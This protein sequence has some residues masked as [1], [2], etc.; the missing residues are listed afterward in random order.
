[1]AKEWSIWAT[2][3]SVCPSCS[4]N[5]S[6]QRLKE[7]KCNK[8][9]SCQLPPAQVRKRAFV[10]TQFQRKQS[11]LIIKD[12]GCMTSQTPLRVRISGT[13]VARRTK[14]GHNVHHTQAVV[15][16]GSD[17]GLDPWGHPQAPRKGPIKEECVSESLSYKNWCV[18]RA[19]F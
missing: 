2:T 12:K 18:I 7:C 16:S 11:I 13:T 6:G 1:M 8:L 17:L 5:F 14:F 10:P 15:L 19:V 3:E 9:S 4:T